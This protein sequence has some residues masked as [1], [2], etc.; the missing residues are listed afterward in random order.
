MR[1]LNWLT[2]ISG[3]DRESS[4]PEKPAHRNVIDEGFWP[5]LTGAELLKTDKRRRIIRVLTEN[6]PLS[7]Q[8]TDA[9]WLRP[10]E[11][12]SARVQDS[13]A[14]WNGSYSNPGGFIDMSMNVA[15][16][17]VRLVRGMMLPSGAPPEEQAEQ[18]PGWVCA[19]YWA[20]LFHHLEWLTQIE[21]ALKSGRT[22]HPGLSIPR[23]DWRVRPKSGAASIHNGIYIA[24]RLLPEAGM[25]W[26]QRWPMMAENLMLFLSGHRVESGILNSIIS[27]ARNSCDIQTRVDFSVQ[28][29]QIAPQTQANQSDHITPKVYETEPESL[30]SLSSANTPSNSIVSDPLSYTPASQNEVPAVISLPVLPME[31]AL[32]NDNAI[33]EGEIKS[34]SGDGEPTKSSTGSLLSFL[35]LMAEGLPLTTSDSSLEDDT[36]GNLNI[37]D[38]V[39]TSESSI[40]G[41]FLNWL[42]DNI[43][44]GTLSVNERESLIH[45]LTQFVYL[46]SPACFYRYISEND[47]NSEDKD[48]LQKSFEAMSIHHSRNGKG[49]FHYHKYDTPDKSGRYTKVSGYMIKADIVFKK[50]SCPPDSV[51]ISAKNNLLKKT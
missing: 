39:E 32:L 16:R 22:W 34:T 33:P 35:D 50:G 43:E 28:K 47:S 3:T 49:L 44:N 30:S 41:L 13:P 24:A 14:S 8:V 1:M 4:K 10:L 29:L 6:S 37:E 18:A 9:W 31:S 45:V 19:V 5:A 26:L 40:G 2:G 38:S 23:E 36:D 11:E 17:A 12:L 46:V 42:R 51:W 48:K 7:H 27:E 25:I 20:G 21:G 15:V